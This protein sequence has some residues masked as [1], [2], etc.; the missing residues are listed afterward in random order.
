MEI[1]AVVYK[2]EQFP[3]DLYQRALHVLDP[4][5]VA[6]IQ[7][8]YHREDA[9]RTLIG[10]LLV[11]KL[12][13]QRG[14]RNSD[15][16]FGT[17]SAKKPYITTSGVDPPIAYNISHDN[18]LI[19]MAFAPG[20]HDP[21]AF[22]LGV[23]VMKVRIPDRCT[24]ASFVESVSDTL[25]P[26]EYTSLFSNKAEAERLKCFFWLWTL[27]EAYTKAL[28]LGLGFDFRR[29][30]YDIEKNIIRVDKKI[31]AAWR[32]TKFNLTEE[33]DRYQGVVAEYIGGSDTE[34][35]D[36]S[37]SPNRV[38]S[39]NAVEFVEAVIQELKEA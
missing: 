7:R 26:L 36:S 33:I 27:K 3:E 39:W 9:C 21:P 5:S 18:G 30:E 12:L 8:F 23:D 24:F 13:K 4:Q 19:V 31:A 37:T 10:R 16:S 14:I 34:I 2:P 1:W 17:T 6:R 25:T 29:V 35:V 15:M 28:G 32:F 22:S 20:I 11:R 38:V